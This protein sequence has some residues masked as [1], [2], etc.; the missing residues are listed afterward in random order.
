M[1]T[2][3]SNDPLANPHYFSGLMDDVRIYDRALSA[4]EIE[5]LYLGEEAE[6]VGLEIT[7]PS[8]VPEDSQ[9]QYSAIALYD[10]NSTADVTDTAVWS[11]EP[12]V[13]ADI[14]AGLLTTEDTGGLLTNSVVPSGLGRKSRRETLVPHGVKEKAQIGLGLLKDAVLEFAKANQDGVTNSD[15]ASLLGLRSDY[16]GGSKDYL[17]YSVFGILMREGKIERLAGSHK[18]IARVE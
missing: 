7:G 6:L 18:H 15:A 5:E 8:Q 12:D 1:T 10:N 16:G 13:I 4:V 11:V 3:V 2:T 9:T 17:S 14:E